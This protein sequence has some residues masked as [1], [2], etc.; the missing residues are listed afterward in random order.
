MMNSWFCDYLQVFHIIQ[1]SQF[2]DS[3]AKNPK[4]KVKEREKEKEKPL[5]NNIP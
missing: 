4:V 1:K 3:K 2:H 5:R